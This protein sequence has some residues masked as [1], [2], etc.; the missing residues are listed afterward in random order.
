MEGT[1]HTTEEPTTS[2]DLLLDLDLEL[3]LEP[4]L[5]QSGRRKR[6]INNCKIHYSLDF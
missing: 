1:S 3:E 4:E 6:E 5:C 2:R